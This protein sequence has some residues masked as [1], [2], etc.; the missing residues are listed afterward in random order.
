MLSRVADSLYWMSRYIERAENV[1]RFID[2][3]LHLMLDLP[4]GASEQWKPLVITT[5]D[6]DLF[7][8][9]YQEATRENV[10]QFLTFDRENPNSI[11]SCLRAAR[12]NAR[13]VRE[14]IS[15]SMWEQ[16]NVFYLMVRDLA[17]TA[18]VREVP[19][20]VFHDVRMASHLFEGLT[21]ATMSHGE[22]WHFCRMGRLLERADK[23]SRMVDVKYFLLLPSVADVGTP[24]DDIQWAAVLRSTSALEMY[25]KRY[26]DLSPDRIAE[27]LLLDREFPRSLHYCLIKADESLHA[28]SS[29]PV[30]TFCNPAEQRLGQ[31]RAEL[32]YAQVDNIIRAGLHEFLDA[33]QTKLNQVGD[34]IFTTF[35]ALQP[36]GG[37]VMGNAQSQR[38]GE[39][40][41]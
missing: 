12:E 16:V 10:V 34:S 1:A 25:R 6:D 22:G 33:F 8:E 13:S 29:T 35:F 4:A 31:L 11:L 20:E 37:A 26:Q 27:F 39:G 15:S 30:G 23:T 32:A 24:F 3:N 36:I 7:A 19:Y 28:V 18:R 41:G 38:S 9:R 2:V 5:G 17:T 14:I 21:N 40:K